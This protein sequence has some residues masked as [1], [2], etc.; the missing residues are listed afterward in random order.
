MAHHYAQIE[1]GGIAR[2]A[3]N[4]IKQK[5]GNC[6][7][8]DEDEQQQRQ[9]CG[10]SLGETRC[11]IAELGKDGHLISAGAPADAPHRTDVS[12]FRFGPW[13]RRTHRVQY[14]SRWVPAGCEVIMLRGNGEWLRCR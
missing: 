12:T 10:E 8:R 7:D 14:W 11:G 6:R 5:S 1:R 3:K 4:L 2:G 9:E 13:S